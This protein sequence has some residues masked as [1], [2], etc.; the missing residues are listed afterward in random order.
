MPWK[1]DF[2]PNSFFKEGTTT[3]SKISYIFKDYLEEKSY[4][5]DIKYIA[6]QLY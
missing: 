5:G 6:I 4:T 2:V 3:N 1:L